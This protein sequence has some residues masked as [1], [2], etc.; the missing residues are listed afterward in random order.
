M[1]SKETLMAQQMQEKN[2]MAEKKTL[3]EYGKV[4]RNMGR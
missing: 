3:R 2:F 1:K 4:V